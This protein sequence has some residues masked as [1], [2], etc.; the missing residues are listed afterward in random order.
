MRVTAPIRAAIH[1]GESTAHINEIA[2]KEGML[3]MLENLRRLVLNGTISIATMLN[4]AIN[5]DI[6]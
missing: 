4:A 1:A 6:L 2:L 3:P 5:D